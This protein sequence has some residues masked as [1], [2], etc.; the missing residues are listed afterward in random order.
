M[1]TKSR[2]L[3]LFCLALSC[4]GCDGAIRV[5][6]KVYVQTN[7]SGES[8]AFVD[9]PAHVDP[10]LTPV[11]DAIVTVY[12][13]GDYSKSPIDKSTLWQSSEKTDSKGEFEVGGTTSPF[14]FHAALVVEKKGYKPVTKI[15]L[16]DKLAPHEA[17]IILV[18]DDNSNVKNQ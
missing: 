13:G 2:L 16:H 14:K 15:F 6:G 11:K 8:R 1:L 18:P 3:L 10:G 5:K 4:A 9:E 7:S 12:H 17:I